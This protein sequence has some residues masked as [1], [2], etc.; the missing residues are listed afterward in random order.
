MAPFCLKHIYYLH[1]RRDQRLLLLALGYAVEIL[2][3]FVYFPEV[4]NHL[5]GLHL[6][7]GKLK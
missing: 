1:S 7:D 2:Q 6:R 3:A 5:R 4:L